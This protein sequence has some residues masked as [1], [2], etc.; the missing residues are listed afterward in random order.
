MT[1][2][3]LNKLEPIKLPMDKPFSFFEAAIIEAANSGTE[4][5]KATTETEITLSLTPINRAIPVA[6]PTNH[7][8]PKYKLKPPII[9]KESHLYMGISAEANASF[10]CSF[11]FLE[12]DIR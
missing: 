3:I 4:V 9:K 5:P 11:S 1:A 6:P 8:V 7:W 12:T 10:F 2:S